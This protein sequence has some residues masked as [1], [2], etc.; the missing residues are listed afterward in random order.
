[1]HKLIL[2]KADKGEIESYRRQTATKIGESFYRVGN[3]QSVPSLTRTIAEH[4][5][6]TGKPAPEPGYRLTETVPEDRD[7]FRDN[8]WEVV[9]VESYVSD[10]PVGQE[11]S[12]IVICYCAYKPLAVEDSWTK[13]ADR[14]APSL[15]SFAGDEEAYQQW[16]ASQKKT[17]EV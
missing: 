15:D 4:Y 13:K 7:S 16:L 10:L 2:F 14:L 11:F 8:G 5:D 1:M 6:A 3:V 9:R 12:E 17:A